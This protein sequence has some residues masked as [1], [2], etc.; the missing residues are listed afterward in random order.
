M[1]L[2]SQTDA[3]ELIRLPQSNVALEN[4]CR[5]VPVKRPSYLPF[6]RNSDFIGRE[7]ILAELDRKIFDGDC[8][9]LALYGLGGIGK[10]Q[11]ALSFAFTVQRNRPD[12]SVFW[13]SAISAESFERSFYEIAVR[14]SVKKPEQQANGFKSAVQQYLSSDVAGKWLLIVDNVDDELSFN[15]KYELPQDGSSTQHRSADIKPFLPNS[16]L[17]HILFTTRHRRAATSLARNHCVELRD[18]SDTEAT[19]LFKKLVIDRVSTNDENSI[20]ELVKELC[21]L[22]LAIIQA[23][24]YLNENPQVTVSDYLKLLR[25]AEHE[26][27]NLLSH[28]FVDDTRYAESDNAVAATWMVS[29]SQIEQVEPLAA[30]LLMHL[31]VL[32]PT[33]IPSSLFMTSEPV[34]DERRTRAVGALCSYAFLRRRGSESDE[35]DM[36]RLV[37][38][39]AR[40]WT[41]RQTNVN[42][43]IERAVRHICQIFSRQRWGNRPIWR[44]LL[45]HTT[46]LLQDRVTDDMKER[47][48][49]CYY[50]GR[51]MYQE[52][53]FAECQTWLL[54]ADEW[55][56]AHLIEEDPHRLEV[57]HAL[58]VTYLQLGRANDS[59]RILEHVVD[60]DSRTREEGDVSRIAS[61]HVLANA[62]LQ[63]ERFP[64]AAKLL[65]HVHEVAKKMIE[66]NKLAKDSDVYSDLQR[67]LAASLQL[68]GR[69]NEAISV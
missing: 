17:G 60:V 52:G 64:E 12:L 42:E 54:Q 48:F 34:D 45:T 13:A 4:D 69:T 50:L 51:C 1:S 53:R 49:L 16:E 38:K 22:P 29:I 2:G 56:R 5:L 24:A 68:S 15:P 11:V 39:V 21:H 25:R 19:L 3:T 37:H 23:S 35:Y 40:L 67:S 31:S 20:C 65:E 61:R 10:T 62:Y 14:C 18:M 26:G 9:K 7:A 36:H 57:E 58:G 43:V 44:V 27:V 28:D 47:R 63:D 6:P 32:E 66:N 8:A 33:S 59:M 46:G 30:D 41:R 55:Y